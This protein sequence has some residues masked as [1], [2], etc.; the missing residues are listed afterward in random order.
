MDTLSRSDT[1]AREPRTFELRNGEWADTTPDRRL[2]VSRWLLVPAVLAALTGI[3]L[4]LFAALA[5]LATGGL[6]A[7][8]SVVVDQVARLGERIGR[9]LRRSRP[10]SIAPRETRSDGQ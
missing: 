6:V 8:R 5:A 4:I 2:R 10:T 1:P 3:V 7:L 9:L